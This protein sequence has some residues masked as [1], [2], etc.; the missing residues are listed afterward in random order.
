MKSR[1]WSWTTAPS[2]A[3]ATVVLRSGNAKTGHVIASYAAHQSCP[4]DC[5]L[6]PKLADNGEWADDMRKR[7]C[8]AAHAQASMAMRRLNLRAALN[9][10]T[11]LSIALAE[12]RLFD[13]VRV[14]KSMR[15]RPI[16][17][18][19]GGDCATSAAA[20][21]VSSAVGR[22]IKRGSGKAWSYSHA[23]RKMARSDWGSVSVLASCNNDADRR[24]AK[25][26]GWA[27]AQV[28]PEGVAM[29]RSGGRFDWV[30]GS[31]RFTICPAQVAER[32]GKSFACTSCPNLCRDD[33][34]MITGNRTVVFLTHGHLSAQVGC[35]DAALGYELPILN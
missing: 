11:S 4:N 29:A 17:V 2:A 35:A 13:T 9:G 19:V 1:D 33:Q 30:E 21:I 27:T 5:P 10:D 12:A 20:R 15:G 3:P 22:L 34:K 24:D 31:E 25:V 18:H 23:W 32:F 26:A 16:R 7:S 28:M 8:Y 6:L 14:T